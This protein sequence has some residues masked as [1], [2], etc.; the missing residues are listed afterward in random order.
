MILIDMYRILFL[1]GFLVVT[2]I[3]KNS[4]LYNIAHQQ[5]IMMIKKYTRVHI[6]VDA[7][8]NL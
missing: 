5:K 6:T 4:P 2:Q 7:L 3:L 1:S 8:L